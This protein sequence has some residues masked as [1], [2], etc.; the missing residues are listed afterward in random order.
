MKHEEINL[1]PNNSQLIK[2][3]LSFMMKYY[4][5]VKIMIFKNFNSKRKC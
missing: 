2:L 4:V 5:I 1:L 3:W